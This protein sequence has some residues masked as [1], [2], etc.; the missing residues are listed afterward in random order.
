METSPH[1]AYPTIH[2]PCAFWESKLPSGLPHP[3]SPPPR[4]SALG[5]NGHW[6]YNPARFDAC[7]MPRQTESAPE[8]CQQSIMM[9]RSSKGVPCV[10]LHASSMSSMRMSESPNSMPAPD[11]KNQRRKQAKE[12]D[13]DTQSVSGSIPG[14]VLKKECKKH[15]RHPKEDQ[16]ANV[17]ASF[18]VSSFSA[19][20]A[21]DTS[22][23]NGSGSRSLQPS[24]TAATP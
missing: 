15:Q 7:K 17:S 24:P 1:S 14:D 2:H 10:P 9:A 21:Q 13:S 5:E 3:R 8:Q 16:P 18:K 23:S 22:R 12:K 11:G 4:P 6:Q 19:K 20:E